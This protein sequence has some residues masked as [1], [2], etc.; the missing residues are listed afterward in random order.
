MNE[1]R[2]NAAALDNALRLLR[3]RRWIIRMQRIVIALLCAAL[4][5]VCSAT[6]HAAQADTEDNNRCTM[7]SS[8]MCTEI[9]V[10]DRRVYVRQKRRHPGTAHT[11]S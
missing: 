8:A 9:R 3:R 11:V 1:N 7:Q 5:A 10:P 2:A 4:I 6:G